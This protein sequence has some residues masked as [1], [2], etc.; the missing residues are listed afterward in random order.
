M[1]GMPG[2][3]AGMPGQIPM[4]MPG[5]M[6]GHMPAAMPQ[7]PMQMPMMYGQPQQQP[8]Y[9]QPQRS[10]AGS[11]APVAHGAVQSYAPPAQ[12]TASYAPQAY[13]QPQYAQQR[14]VQQA[15]APA[16]AAQPAPIAEEKIT[17]MMTGRDGVNDVINGTFTSCGNHGGRYCFYAPT[18]EGPIYLYYDQQADNWCIGDQIGSQS[19]YAVCGPSN[20]EDMAQEWRIWTGD[21]WENDPKIVATIK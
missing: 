12:P 9:A 6:P 13:A 7:M 2:G 17:V 11:Y 20:G 19:Y 5:P 14:V 16:P 1:T 18:N 10:Y 8:V 4:G 3:M 15:P 21:N